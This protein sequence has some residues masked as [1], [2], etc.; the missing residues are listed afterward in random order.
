MKSPPDM[1]ADIARALYG[2]QWRMALARELGINDKTIT[3]WMT[4]RTPLPADHGVFGALGGIVARAVVEA[5]E[6]QKSLAALA[7]EIERWQRHKI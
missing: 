5:G 6:R 1:L 3:R 7:K 4:G 2:E